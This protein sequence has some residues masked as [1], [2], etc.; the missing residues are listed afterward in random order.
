MSRSLELPSWEAVKIA[1]ARGAGIA[2]VSRLALELELQAGILVV[3]DLPR[4]QVKRMISAV[5]T[6]DVPLG[7]AAEL[8]LELLRGELSG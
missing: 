3:L 1:V 7:P 8:F 5:Y 2:A 4:W 6:R